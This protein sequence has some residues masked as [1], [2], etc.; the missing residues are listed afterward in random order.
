MTSLNRRQFTRSL[1][2]LPAA[3]LVG[4]GLGSLAPA[5]ASA[6]PAD[7]NTHFLADTLS[8][9]IMHQVR[10]G[11]GNWNARWNEIAPSTN[12]L[13]ALSAA[14]I[15]KDLHV[16]AC[17]GETGPKH[18]I[19]NADGSWKAFSPIPSQ[20]GPT[21]LV[22]RMAAASVGTVLHVFAAMRW[23]GDLYH[24]VRNE[25]G[26]WWA[27]WKLL[28]TFTSIDYLA[29]A[30][31]G[32]TIDTA[33]VS[34]GE[35]VHAIRSS[36]GTWSGWGNIESAAGEI[37]DIRGVTL[38]GI[39]SSLHVVALTNAYSIHHAIRNVDATWQRF[40]EVPG[41]TSRGPFAASAANA[42]GELQLGVLE[43]A[44]G[45]Q[46]GTHTIRHADGTWQTVRSIPTAGLPA[47]DN[48]LA[49][50]ALAATPR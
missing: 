1:L 8:G 4:T 17:I 50:V 18:A 2:A 19:R 41:F 15:A 24:T 21:G 35:I 40:R 11:G 31:V 44:D 6:A 26:T 37:G 36:G 38:A 14:G 13:Y 23:S 33:V 49:M 12:A 9:N 39:G 10:Y 22:D 29:A 46:V 47:T 3:A 32:T 25:D 20:S 43:L 16:V 30:R 45:K 34:N 27:N 42:G 28:R 7:W 5:A 48:D